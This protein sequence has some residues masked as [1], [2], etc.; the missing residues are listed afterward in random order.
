MVTIGLDA[1]VAALKGVRT[2]T[3]GKLKR[4]G[5]EVVSHTRSS[6]IVF[7]R[8]R[9]EQLEKVAALAYVRYVEPARY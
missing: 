9:V 3:V 7:A 1:G 6:K 2:Q 5:V 8:V 4:L